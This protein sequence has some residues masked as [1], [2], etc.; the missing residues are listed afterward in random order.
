MIDTDV[1]LNEKIQKMVQT[2]NE[3][4]PIGVTV[5]AV[6]SLEGICDFYILNKGVPIEYYT[7]MCDNKGNY[8][9]MTTF[10]RD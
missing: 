10:I 1:Q 7:L 9:Y 4:L 3:K 5:Q 2:L 6:H 8:S